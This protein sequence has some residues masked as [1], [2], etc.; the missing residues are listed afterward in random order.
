[1]I[2][3]VARKELL[4]I[5]R[6]GRFRWLAVT[7]VLLIAVATASGLQLTLGQLEDQALFRK[8]DADGSGCIEMREFAIL[9]RES[10]FVI[11]RLARG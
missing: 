6:D 8:Y 4:E 10:V 3:V 2:A 9:V 7:C 1:M 11:V 5:V